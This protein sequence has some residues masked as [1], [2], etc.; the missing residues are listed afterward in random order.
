[1]LRVAQAGGPDEIAGL[2]SADSLLAATP[3]EQ[4]PLTAR[5]IAAVEAV[6][7]PALRAS[8]DACLAGLRQAQ[9]APPS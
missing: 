7:D 1:M 8:R 2:C 5:A 6:N 4:G 9:A 3:A